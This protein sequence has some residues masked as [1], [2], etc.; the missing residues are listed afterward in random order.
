MPSNLELKKSLQEIKKQ[1]LLKDKT[2]ADLNAQL[3]K[4]LE[5]EESAKQNNVVNSVNTTIVEEIVA[6]SVPV[7]PVKNTNTNTTPLK[8]SETKTVDKKK[9]KR[10]AWNLYLW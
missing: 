9:K 8:V 3:S 5:L 6:G 4:F 7:E 10:S 1:L 2:I